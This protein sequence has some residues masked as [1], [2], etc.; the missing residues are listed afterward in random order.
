MNKRVDKVCILGDFAVGKSSI[1]QRIIN[2]QFNEMSLT[3]VGASVD[4]FDIQIAANNSNDSEIGHKLHQIVLWDISGVDQLDALRTDYI[5]GMTAYVLV[6]DATR[7]PTM[8]TAQ[9]LHQQ[10][11]EQF[12]E[13][14]FCLMINKVDLDEE[15]EVSSSDIV[16]SGMINWPIHFT[17]AK[18]GENV[19]QAIHA[20]V[21]QSHGSQHHE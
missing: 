15:N 12:G 20:L 6:C 8:N 5:T 1:V 10:I 19:N 9:T 3:T 4:S 2:G 21:T 16:R 14:P 13:L 18:T 7:R 17:S 11:V